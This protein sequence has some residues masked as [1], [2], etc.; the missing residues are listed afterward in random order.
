MP[1]VL[2]VSSDPCITHSCAEILRSH[3]LTAFAGPGAAEAAQAS[4]DVIL[5]WHDGE[6][7]L[8]ALAGAYPRVP[9]VVCAYGQRIPRPASATVV[10]L[11]FDSGRLAQA[12]HQAVR[13]REHL[14]AA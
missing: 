1:R 8:D 13:E 5:V 12:L 9:L 6:E 11:P 2:I 10:P 7:D 4:P 14:T 3:G